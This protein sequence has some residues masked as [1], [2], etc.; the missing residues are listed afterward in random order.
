MSRLQTYKNFILNNAAQI[1]SLESSVRSLTYLLYGRL[2]NADIGVE[3][4]HASVDLIS[5]FHNILLD[6]EITQHSQSLPVASQLFN[7]YT[8]EALS[9]SKAY[10]IVAYTLT[11]IRHVEIIVEMFSRKIGGERLQWNIVTFLET[12]KLTCR[13]I[14]LKLLKNR[15]LLYPSV[16][17][18]MQDLSQLNSAETNTDNDDSD[19]AKWN[20]PRSG[21]QMV[22]ISTIL[23]ENISNEPSMD[24][25]E[26]LL[27]G[28]PISKDKSVSYLLSK[29]LTSPL[30]GP[31]ELVSSFKGLALVGEWVYILR[32]LIYV[33]AIKKY[34]KESWKPWV[35][36]LGLE[37]SSFAAMWN[38][39]IS[40]LEKDEYK[41]R[42]LLIF[43]YLVRNPF[44]QQFTKP[45]IDSVIESSS[46]IPI[47]SL[48]SAIL[49]EYQPLWEEYHF[50]T[51][52]H[53]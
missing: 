6:K 22:R 46:K 27:T 44:Y 41:R 38:K 39:P 16:P 53:N 52:V 28:K 18:P 15:M 34:G 29:A 36:S 47:V 21:K 49:K 19:T 31:L 14:L 13:I 8:R 5:F 32:P 11:I 26:A 37:L 43:L 10:K 4:V 48:F 30:K 23:D 42:V 12:L 45:R 25:F 40:A 1:S 50:Y 3:A 33:L 17:E 20:A 35:L 2:E 9:Q 51:S 24:P 7:R